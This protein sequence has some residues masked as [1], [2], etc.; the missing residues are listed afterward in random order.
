[1]LTREER[2]DLRTCIVKAARHGDSAPANV[3]GSA[4][5]FSLRDVSRLLDALD[6]AEKEITRLRYLT[7]RLYKIVH[8]GTLVECDHKCLTKETKGQL[9]TLLAEAEAA[10]EK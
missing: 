8:L 9:L 5:K 7:G 1:M 2:D 10:L 3:F 6:R 4:S